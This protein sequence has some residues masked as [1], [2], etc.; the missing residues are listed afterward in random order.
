MLPD[1]LKYCIEAPVKIA[2]EINNFYNLPS[3][4]KATFSGIKV[5]SPI[6]TFWHV[7]CHC[8]K[9]LTIVDS[10]RFKRVMLTFKVVSKQ[11]IVMEH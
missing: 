6:F 2:L 3:R 5:L 8:V 7:I 1:V 10:K 4:E 11:S 9:Y